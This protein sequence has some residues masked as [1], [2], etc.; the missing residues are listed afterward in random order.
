VPRAKQRSREKPGKLAEVVANRIE[1]DIVARGWPIGAVLG[2]ESDLLQEYGVSRAVLREAVRIVEHHLVGVMRRG[3]GGGLVVTAPDLGAVARAVTLQLEFQ[4]IQPHHL[5]ETRTALEL[6]CVRLACERLSPAGIVRLREHRET[7]GRGSSAH[8]TDF[9][10]LVAELTGNPAMSLFI[11]VLDILMSDY[12][13][14]P[15]SSERIATELH[16]VHRQIAEAIIAR[17]VTLAERRMLK[18][19][20]SVQGWLAPQKSTRSRARARR[21]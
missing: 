1:Q 17:D 21:A 15:A 11:R 9:H 7:P 16:R 8:A 18:H 3:P 5:Y 12:L 6:S 13:A 10:V 20:Q 4:N 19:L 14:M 2:S